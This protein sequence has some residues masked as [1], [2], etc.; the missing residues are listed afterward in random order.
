M[1]AHNHPGSGVTTLITPNPHSHTLDYTSN[2]TNPGVKAVEDGVKVGT[3]DTSAVT[4]TATSPL[5]IVTDGGGLPHDN[6]Q[7]VLAC[8]YIMYIPLSFK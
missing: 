5:T 7:P 2:V 4:L 6:K 1:P 8:Y 3:V